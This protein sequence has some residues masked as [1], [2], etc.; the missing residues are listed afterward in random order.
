MRCTHCHGTNTRLIEKI[1]RVVYDACEPE[2]SIG[3]IRDCYIEERWLCWTCGNPFTP[4]VSKVMAWHLRPKQWGKP[5]VRRIAKAEI[6]KEF[7]EPPEARELP[8]DDT[9]FGQLLE[10]AFKHRYGDDFVWEKATITK[11]GAD[12]YIVAI[13]TL[14]SCCTT[15]AD[16]K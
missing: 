16:I 13:D 5:K 11:T 15:I 9:R 10:L 12:S 14:N 3:T 8:K 1:C 7:F 2:S 4:S 6:I